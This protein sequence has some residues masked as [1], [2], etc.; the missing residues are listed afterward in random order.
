MTRRVNLSKN[1]NARKNLFF[2]FLTRN[3]R[4]AFGLLDDVLLLGGRCP[5]RI[6]E[7]VEGLREVVVESLALHKKEITCNVAKW[8]YKTLKKIVLQEQ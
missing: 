8:I 6:L 3:S 5:L 2:K 4:V 1:Y 7:A